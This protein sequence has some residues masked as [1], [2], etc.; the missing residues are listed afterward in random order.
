LLNSYVNK[1][2]LLKYPFNIWVDYTPYVRD[3]E[4]GFRSFQ[5][6]ERWNSQT[7][8]SIQKRGGIHYLP[9]V[10]LYLAVEKEDLVVEITGRAD[11]IIQ[12]DSGILMEEIKNHYREFENIS[13]KRKI[14]NS[15]H[16]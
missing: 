6:D 15:G 14:P 11:G 4:G 1:N 2:L 7:I 12:T 10:P 9:E 3:I 13:R 8:K 16:N 5:P